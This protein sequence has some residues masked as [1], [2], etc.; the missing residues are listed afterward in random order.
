M[1]IYNDYRVSKT[2]KREKNDEKK[3]Q[4]KGGTC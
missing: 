4:S 2:Q 1:Y 3:E